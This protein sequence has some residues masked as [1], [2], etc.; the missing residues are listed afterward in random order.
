MRIAIISENFHP[1]RNS[2]SVQ[3]RDLCGELIRLGHDVTAIVP[4]CDIKSSWNIEHLDGYKILRLKT[5]KIKDVSY[6]RRAVAEMLMPLF[7]LKAYIKSPLSNEK[8]EGVI[9]YSPSIFHGLFAWYLKTSSGC[10]GY[11]IVRDIFPKWAV[12][13]G[14]MSGYGLPYLFFS[15]IA[16]YQ[17]SVADTIGVQTKGNLKYFRWRKYKSDCKLEVLQNW[18]AKAVYKRCTLRLDETSLR[19][20]KIFIYAGNMGP[21][22]GMDI[23]LDLAKQLQIRSDIGFVFVGRGKDMA[24]LNLMAE[25]LQLDNILFFNEIHPDEIID[26]YKQCTVGIVA[27]HPRHKSH[28]IPGKFLTYMQGGLPILANINAGNDLTTLIRDEGV[29]QVSENNQVDELLM[30]TDLLLLQIEQGINFSDRCKNLFRRKFTVEIA[31][32][33][34]CNALSK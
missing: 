32:V 6:L 14:L 7:S 29:G 28:N 27:L 1:I 9:W 19:G 15:A 17:Y 22:Q 5:L 31:A 12:D 16:R 2:G 8:W 10:R 11:L 21:A 25:K 4:A 26:L 13:M 24:R 33:Q 3:L 34:I 23:F 18:L 30:L 20:R